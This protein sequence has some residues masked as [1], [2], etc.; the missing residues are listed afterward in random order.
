MRRIT[1]AIF[2][3]LATLSL[4]AQPKD[5]AVREEMRVNLVELEVKVTSLGGKI[6][7]GLTPDDFV[8]TENGKTQK[9]DS[10]EEV[11]LGNLPEE[12]AQDYHSRIMI[13]LDMRNTSFPLMKRVFP[14]LREFVQTQYDGR[15]ELGLAIN[16]G[17]IVE[18]LSFTSDQERIFAAIDKIERAYDKN[19]FRSYRL[20]EDVGFTGYSPGYDDPYTPRFGASPI[21]GYSNAIRN[22]YRSEIEVLGQFVHYLGTYSGKKNLLLIS[23]RW[24]RSS[25]LDSEGTVDQEGVIS[26]KDIQTACMYNKIS[27]NVL[28]L[29]RGSHRSGLPLG[30]D[31][32]F[33]D[34]GNPRHNISRSSFTIDESATLA[35]ATSG[36]L[37]K[38]STQQVA[39][40]VDRAIEKSSRYYR[41]RYYS[42]YSGERFRNV[43]VRAKGFSRIAY[44]LDGYFPKDAEVG[45]LRANASLTP[46]T[47][48]EYDLDMSTHWMRWHW[49]GWGKRRANY[50]IAHRAYDAEGRLLAE[51]VT[52]GAAVKQRKRYHTLELRLTL[53][54]PAAVKPARI[55]VV[56]TDLTSGKRVTF[57]DI[58]GDLI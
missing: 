50:A 38:A 58:R 47:T 54:L 37:F 44:S 30:K 16:A 17:G 14:Q 32:Y 48:Q 52:A 9:I 34:Y 57:D 24:F 51:K 19:K 40:F 42:Q 15:M 7:S 1:T 25:A 27:I 28:N 56:V 2:S 8:V 5:T 20:H 10:F 12:E 21:D 31:D 6:L 11:D 45:K 55:E 13:L 22:H 41:I 43:N 35:A 29:V 39:R 4:W 53:P 46:V 49:A 36:F 23:E 18:F 33:V 26:L 3:L